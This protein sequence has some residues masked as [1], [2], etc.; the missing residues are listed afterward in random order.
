MNIEKWY[1]NNTTPEFREDVKA[2]HGLDFR[3]FE[4]L[5]EEAG[6][7]DEDFSD[8]DVK[9]YSE[10]VYIDGCPFLNFRFQWNR[11]GFSGSLY[12]TFLETKKVWNYQEWK[13]K[14]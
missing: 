11:K 14:K 6:I 7:L 3:Q 1:W 4:I 10:G 5:A 2:Y 9:I 8:I 13:L 12:D